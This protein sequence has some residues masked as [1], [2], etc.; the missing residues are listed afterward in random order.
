MTVEAFWGGRREFFEFTVSKREEHENDP[1]HPWRYKPDR[2]LALDRIPELPFPTVRGSS[3]CAIQ[4]SRDS[5][6]VTFDLQGAKISISTA[7]L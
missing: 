1:N 4:W 2:K 7:D 5:S 3:P 6:E